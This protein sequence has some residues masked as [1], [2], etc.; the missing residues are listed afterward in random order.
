[1]FETVMGSSERPR[2]VLGTTP[3]AKSQLSIE[4]I[5]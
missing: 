3:S 1:M 4:D 5:R 2:T